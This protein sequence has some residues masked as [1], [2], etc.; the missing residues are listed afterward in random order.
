ML[1]PLKALFTEY[2]PEFGQLVVKVATPVELV[3]AVPKVAPVVPS[4]NT[5]VRPATR[6]DSV[7]V[8]VTA[9]PRVVLVVDAFSDK[10]VACSE[11]ITTAADV[12]VA[13]ALVPA[14]TAVTECEPAAKVLLKVATP[15]VLVV[16]E[17]SKVDPS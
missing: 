1:V 10:V 13:Y 12:D 17:P 15:E 7:A 16:A 14:N 4:W 8:K 11:V 3:V 5:T 2:V 6:T 9:V